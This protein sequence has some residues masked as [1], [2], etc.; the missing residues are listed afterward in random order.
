M[1]LVVHQRHRAGQQALVNM[2]LER[3]AQAGKGVGL[4]GWS[5]RCF[6]NTS[7]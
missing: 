2:G 5:R 6:E 7:A 3:G 4:H 1:A